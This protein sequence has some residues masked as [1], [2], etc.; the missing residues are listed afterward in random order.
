MTQ[1]AAPLNPEG[2][3]TPVAVRL[4]DADLDRL[5][6]LIARKGCLN[7]SAAFRLVLSA[8]FDQLEGKS[9]GRRRRPPAG[10]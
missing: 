8:G 5:A 9:K 7:R 1:I 3:S 4:G 6:D 2:P 10:G